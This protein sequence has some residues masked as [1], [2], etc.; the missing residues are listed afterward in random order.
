MA[1]KKKEKKRK[2]KLIYFTFYIADAWT[3]IASSVP[4]QTLKLAAK[5]QKKKIKSHRKLW[6]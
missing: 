2:L 4:Y 5:M 3:K 1:K 6:H